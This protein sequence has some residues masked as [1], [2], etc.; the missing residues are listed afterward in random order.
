MVSIGGLL[1]AVVDLLGLLKVVDFEQRGGL[2]THPKQTMLAAVAFD[3]LGESFSGG[4]A[5]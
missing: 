5:T 4:L 3:A 1:V 2:H